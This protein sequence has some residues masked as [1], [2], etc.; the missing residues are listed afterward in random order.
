M[1][2]F[3]FNSNWIADKGICF[4]T[5]L[6]LIL[7]SSNKPRLLAQDAPKEIEKILNQQAERWNAKD[8]EGFMATYWKSENLTFS[9]GGKTTRGWQATLDRYQSKYPPEKMGTLTFNNLETTILNE[10]A[11]LVLGNWYLKFKDKNPSGNFSLVLKKI[12]GQWKIV[13]DHSSSLANSK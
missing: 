9:S 13:H 4:A 3:F 6:L 10:N 11:A 7:C 8:L 5:I 12:K 1:N 2:H